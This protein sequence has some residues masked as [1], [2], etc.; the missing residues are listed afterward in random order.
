MHQI[1]SIVLAD[2]GDCFQIG[3]VREEHTIR[4]KDDEATSFVCDLYTPGDGSGEE[5]PFRAK[6]TETQLKP[7]DTGYRY[8]TDEFLVQSAAF[9]W[10]AGFVAE[11][12]APPPADAAATSAESAFTPAS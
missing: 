1:H 5:K 3:V 12:E 6:F 11:L 2:C 7:L 4:T 10:A 8:G 9:K